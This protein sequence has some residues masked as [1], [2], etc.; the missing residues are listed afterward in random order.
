MDPV[1]TQLTHSRVIAVVGL[2]PNPKRPSH[3]VARYLQEQ[4]YRIIPVNPAVDEVLGEKSFPDLKSIPEPI[5]MVDIFRRSDL[6]PPVVAEAIE[7]GVKYVWMQDGVVNQEAARA[8]RQA[9]IPVI[10]D[11]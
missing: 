4:G 1:E 8:A 7:I 5:D 2:S 9:G 10:M 3:D 6:V 11:N